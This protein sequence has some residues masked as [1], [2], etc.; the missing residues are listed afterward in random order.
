MRTGFLLATLT[1]ALVAAYPAQA[2]VQWV[3]ASGGTI[4]GGAVQA[5]N[6]ANGA[7]LY[8]CRAQYNGGLHP[9]KTRPGFNGCNIPYGGQELTV[10]VYDIIID[11]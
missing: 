4:P 8:I 9:G 5:G 3:R 7:P 10:P 1:L 11:R 2:R 6:E